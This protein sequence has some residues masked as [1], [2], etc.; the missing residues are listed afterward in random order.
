MSYRYE[1]RPCEFSHVNIGLEQLIKII[2]VICRSV[3]KLLVVNK[4]GLGRNQS[5]HRD[6]TTNVD[7]ISDISTIG[8]DQDVARTGECLG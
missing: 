4:D 1:T 7:K 8:S 5:G 6:D 3:L 2:P